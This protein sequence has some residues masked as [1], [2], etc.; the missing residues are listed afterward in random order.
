[1]R[2]CFP[3][4][5]VFGAV[6]YMTSASCIVQAADEE[7]DSILNQVASSSSINLPDV[8]KQLPRFIAIAAGEDHQDADLAIRAIG[9]LGEYNESVIWVLC[10]KLTDQRHST[11]ELAVKALVSIGE[12]SI[13]EVRKM[14]EF[15]S[16]KARAAAGEVLI[17]LGVV[18]LADLDQ[19]SED[20]D[21]RAR[22]VAASGYAKKGKAGVAGLLHLLN[23]DELAVATLAAKGLSKNQTAPEK[24]VATLTKSLERRH[25]EQSAASALLSYGIHAQRAIPALLKKY[26]EYKFRDYFL[27]RT[28]D[29]LPQTVSR[30]IG[31]PHPDDTLRI[32]EFLTH[33]NPDV[34]IFAANLIGRIGVAAEEVG[35]RLSAEIEPSWVRYKKAI[36]AYESQSEDE[37]LNYPNHACVD[38]AYA[39]WEVTRNTPKFVQLMKRIVDVDGIWF[40][41]GDPNPWEKFTRDDAVQL[42]SFL[43]SSTQ[44]EQEFVLRVIALIGPPA[45][46]MTDQ[47]I[48]IAENGE[49]KLSQLAYMALIAIGPE[50][51]DRVDP[52]LVQQY[53]TGRVTMLQ[54]G[55]IANSLKLRSESVRQILLGGLPKS[56]NESGDAITEALAAIDSDFAANAV[57]EL[58]AEKYPRVTPKRVALQRYLTRHQLGAKVLV[59]HLISMARGGLYNSRVQAVQALGKYGSRAEAAVDE[60]VGYATNEEAEMKLAAA[61]AIYRINGER[62]RLDELLESAYSNPRPHN[63][64]RAS[65]ELMELEEFAAPYV[66]YLMKEFENEKSYF[67][68]GVIE[69]LGKIGTKESLE[70]LRQIADSSHWTKRNR[71][72]EE[73]RKI[74]KTDPQEN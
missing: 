9:K 19:L 38:L 60:L 41:D 13:P 22:A 30:R 44:R 23:D 74:G 51:S 63:W 15:D 25:F 62:K 27:D 49:K 11:R 47:I 66:T 14:L 35:P 70:E 8:Q 73:L 4:S 20:I 31:P 50:V 72:R 56:S 65:K 57:K 33:E 7:V 42:S 6:V 10:K 3:K 67:E 29:I 46:E 17:R 26:S 2:G 58:Q 55:Q 45:I 21:P 54:F 1:M 32:C 12:E 24:A 28:F 16:G 59:P 61:A 5:A 43:E 69:T 18:Q 68:H 37:Q 39:Y 40:V 34:Q 64:Y 48:E 71:A 36:T 53:K 52:V